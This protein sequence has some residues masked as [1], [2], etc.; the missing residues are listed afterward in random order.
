MGPSAGGRVGYDGKEF[1]LNPKINE[2]S[3]LDLVVAGTNNAV[4]M[5]ESE[6]NE[7]SEETMLNAVSYGHEE[8]K[9]VIELIINL[10]EACAKDPWEFEYHGNKSL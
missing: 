1:S 9:K 10:A 7:L 2:D 5:V 4:L 3:D 8:S 6:A